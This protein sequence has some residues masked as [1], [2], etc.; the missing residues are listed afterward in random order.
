M[1]AAQIESG[2]RDLIA[3][4][5]ARRVKIYAGTL[6]PFGG[7]N[8]IYGGYYGTAYG[9]TLPNRSTTGSGPAARSTG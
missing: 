4:A 5:H 6:T 8:A 9:E 7:S 2:Y 1:T 3:M